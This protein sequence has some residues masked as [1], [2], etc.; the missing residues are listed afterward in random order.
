MGHILLLFIIELGLVLW[1]SS[2]I[3]RISPLTAS[4]MFYLYAV[5]N[6]A[7]LTPI[8]V[9][10]TGVSV[11]KTFAITS[12]VF[13][14]MAVFGYT[15]RQ[16][17]TSWGRMLFFALIGLLGALVINWFA[18]SQALDYL[19][20]CAGVLIFIGLTAWDTQK[21]RM[22]A[23]QDSDAPVGRI[24]VYCA[25]QL[26]LDFINLFLYLLRFFGRR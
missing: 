16:D 14:A 19:I 20:S 24:A 22:I 4:V 13:G 25:L 26:Y 12:V 1:L 7:A 18:H 23:A 15:T 9:V 10:Y 3:H 11:A 2:A 6:G 21:I 8:F 5:I 17:L